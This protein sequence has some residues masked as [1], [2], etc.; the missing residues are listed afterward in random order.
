MVA[1]S[2]LVEGR[3]SKPQDT[4]ERFGR[5]GSDEPIGSGRFKRV[6]AS[7]AFRPAFSRKTLRYNGPG[8]SVAVLLGLEVIPKCICSSGHEDSRSQ[9]LKLFGI[10]AW[11]RWCGARPPT[12]VVWRA[13]GAIHRALRCAHKVPSLRPI[14]YV[15]AMPSTS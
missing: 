3:P 8:T 11:A 1:R 15:R 12:R 6:A 14:P 5:H 10:R 9:L 4:L 13:P 2:K 7:P